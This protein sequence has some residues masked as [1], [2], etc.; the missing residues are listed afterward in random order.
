MGA[1][2]PSDAGRDLL[3]PPALAVSNGRVAAFRGRITRADFPTPPELADRDPSR[4]PAEH[5]GGLRA[6][7]IRRDGAVCLGR[8]YQQNPLRVLRPVA[9]RP[10]APA[11]LFLMN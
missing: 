8:T 10:G 7:L 1:R 4:A 2:P 3:S 6:E 9:E 5:V 11:L